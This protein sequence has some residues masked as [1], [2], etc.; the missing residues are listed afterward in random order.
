MGLP[1]GAR[2]RIGK[3]RLHRGIAYSP[4]GTRLAVASSIGVWI[5][6]AHTGEELALFTGHSEPVLSVAFSP[7]GKILASGAGRK[8]NWWRED[9]EIRLWDADTGEH[10]TTLT[11][12]P[13]IALTLPEIGQLNV[14]EL[15]FSPDG[16]TL[17]S[18][19]SDGAVRLW[20]IETGQ[21]RTIAEGPF[22]PSIAFSSG[23]QNPCRWRVG[24]QNSTVGRSHRAAPDNFGRTHG[25]RPFCCVLSGW[26]NPREWRLGQDGSVMGYK[27]A[28]RA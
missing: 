20:D 17:A 26:Q 22:V 7:D 23:W 24:L 10:L 15:T 3:G 25:P 14:W 13:E 19:S 6:D 28:F 18:A 5:Y 1:E 12:P 16:K 8:W 27:H 2:Y 9:S 4:D 11:R 21:Y